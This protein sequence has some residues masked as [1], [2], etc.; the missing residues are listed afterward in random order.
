MY[1]PN[2]TSI[3]LGRLA[4]YFHVFFFTF[5][6]CFPNKI[7]ISLKISMN[8]IQATKLELVLL[9]IYIPYNGKVPHRLIFA[10]F[11]GRWKIKLCENVLRLYNKVLRKSRNLNRPNTRLR[12]LRHPTK[13]G[14]G[15]YTGI[16]CGA[17][18]FADTYNLLQFEQVINIIA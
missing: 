14:V 1:N 15:N 4:I 2:I 9:S 16:T 12:N 5:F 3:E 10:E 6:F 8:K 7:N 18:M 11:R 17:I 13:P